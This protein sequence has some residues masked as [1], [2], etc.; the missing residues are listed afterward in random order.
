M[1]G[2]YQDLLVWQKSM[3]LVYEVYRVVKL[4]PKEELYALSNQIRRAAVSIPSNIAEGHQ[5]KTINEFV[6]FLFIAKGSNAELQT[7]L[8][9]CEG[10]NYLSPEQ[11]Q[12]AKALSK[13]VEKMLTSLIHSFEND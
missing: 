3:N 8:L 7:Q 10:L 2:Y 6:N 11:T 1:R 5:R 12:S 13:E 9:I 4:L